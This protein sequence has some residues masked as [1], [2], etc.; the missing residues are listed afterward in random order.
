MFIYHYMI[1]FASVATLNPQGRRD[2]LTMQQ[3]STALL[4]YKNENQ[5]HVI[6]GLVFTNSLLVLPQVI[7]QTMLLIIGQRAKRTTQTSSEWKQEM[8][9]YLAICNGSKWVLDSLINGS[10]SKNN[11][12]KAV[13][14]SG[15]TWKA[16]SKSISPLHLF[17]RF[18][19]M[20]LCVALKQ[21][22]YA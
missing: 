12:A 14:F 13:V 7:C 20:H 8:L 15:L 16:I 21:R 17:Y 10:V 5:I 3:N 1:V 9:W 18:H 22:L 11:P 4:S 6:G 2:I 19:S